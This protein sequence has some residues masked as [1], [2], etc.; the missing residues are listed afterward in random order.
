MSSFVSTSSS[1]FLTE[2]SELE[3]A[4][5]E[6]KELLQ[7]SPHLLYE[8][9]YKKWN[10]MI[11]KGLD[12]FIK[13]HPKTLRRRL[14]R[15][16]P[17]DFRWK[18]WNSLLEI[19]SLD[20]ESQI[21]DNILKSLRNSKFFLEMFIVHENQCLSSQVQ[22]A[23]L[24]Y[25]NYYDYAAKF[26]N[27]YSPLISIDVPRTFPELNIFKDQASQECLFRVL[28]ATANHIP[29]VGYCQGMNFIA[30]LLLIISNFDQERS[31]YSLILILETYGLSGFYK[32]QFP[33]LTKYIQ[34]FDTMFQINIPKLWKHFQDEGIFDPV[35]LHPWFLT[36]FVSTLP[37]KTVVIIWDYL[38]ANGLQSLI[39]IAIALL[40]TLESSLIGQSM[41]NII[42][43]FKSLRISVGINDVTC[44]RMLLSKAKNIHI[45]EEI[46]ATFKV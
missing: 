6:C 41:E 26:L 42:Q 30:A 36:L 9:S 45:S 28:N 22:T 3:Q 34:A 29:D 24:M 16:V 35:Y 15:G 37:L 19:S 40:K 7:D 25:Y 12:Y 11:A 21:N 2:E 20:E 39:S 43:F 13:E 4:I 8:H 38:L 10:R 5:K 1:R 31:F 14:A 18:I 27:K 46:L 23:N 33:L 17:Q 44:A 32:D